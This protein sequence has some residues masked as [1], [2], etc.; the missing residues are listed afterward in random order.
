MFQPNLKFVVLPVPET[1]G[2]TQKNWAVPE[3]THTPFSPKS[4]MGLCWIYP[5]NVPA[6]F[7]VRSFNHS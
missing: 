4:L 3:Y 1:I 2:G 6:K 7:E 5:V